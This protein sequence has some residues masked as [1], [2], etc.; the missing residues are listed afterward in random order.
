MVI[1]AKEANITTLLVAKENVE[2]AQL[3]TGL[4]IIGCST[5]REAINLL[6][7]KVPQLPNRI[8]PSSTTYDQ[9][10]SIDFSESKRA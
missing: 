9:Q 3:V 6:E 2:E 1:K 10:Y 4:K 5:L 8:S 7:G